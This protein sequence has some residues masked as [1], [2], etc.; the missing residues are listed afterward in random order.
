MQEGS[1]VCTRCR[2]PKSM[3]QNAGDSGP[4]PFVDQVLGVKIADA[5]EGLDGFVANFTICA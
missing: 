5:G 2:L 1:D 3:I 4:K